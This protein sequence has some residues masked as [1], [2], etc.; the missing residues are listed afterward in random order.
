MAFGGFD[1][2]GRS[3]PMA[4][5]NTTPLVDVMLVLLVIFIITAPLLT[6]AIRLDLPTA[7]AP[8]A[9]ETPETVTLAIDAQGAL[10]WNDQPVADAEALQARLAEAAGRKPAPELQLRADRETRY[11]RIAEVM[12]AAQRAGI[13]KLGFV[14]EPPRGGATAR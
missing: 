13:A 7:Q 9:P 1:E 8:L 5:I 4:E 2:R 10:F 3:A 14:T 11:Q 6:H 12:A